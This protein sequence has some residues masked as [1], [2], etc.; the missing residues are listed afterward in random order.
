MT[1]LY[2]I[3]QEQRFTLLE[4]EELGGELTPEL[5]ER[6]EITAT[7]LNSK[8]MAYLEVITTKESFNSMI[9]AEIKRLQQLKKVNDNLVTRLKDNLL[10][11]VKTFGS[12]EVGTHKFGTRKSSSIEVEDV[13][14]LPSEYKVITVSERADKT[15]LKKAIQS[16]EV[17][18]GVEL[19]E[20][21]NLKID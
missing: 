14:S 1:T 5:E 10:N 20:H 19:V 17:I 18:D 16:G 6:L 9:D 7:Q 4:I 11:A 12:F 13:N 21:L 8:S 2:D 3:T 15:A